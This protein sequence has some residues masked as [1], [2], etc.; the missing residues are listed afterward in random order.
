[1]N[2]EELLNEWINSEPLPFTEV[3]V[4]TAEEIGKNVP[5]IL[6][7]LATLE[8]KM[9]R[10]TQQYKREREITE[11]TVIDGMMEAAGEK[12]KKPTVKQMETMAL[13][14]QEVYDAVEKEQQADQNHREIKNLFDIYKAVFDAHTAYVGRGTTILKAEGY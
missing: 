2:L 4:E 6:V 1:M 7:K 5:R 8:A 3:S 9:R 10:E 12:G 13:L 14:S 11:A